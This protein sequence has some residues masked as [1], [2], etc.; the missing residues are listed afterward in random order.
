MK[1]AVIIPSRMNSSRFPGKPLKKILGYTMIEHCYK[2]AC[3]SKNVDDVFVA[4]C[5]SE[6]KE[7]IESIGG[8]VVITSS[9]HKRA[10]T[11]TEEAIEILN[12]KYDLKYDLIIMLQGDEPLIRPDSITK[13][14]NDCKSKDLKILNLIAPIT[15]KEKFIDKNNVKVVFDKNMHALYFSREPIPSSWLEEENIE[16]KFMQIGVIGFSHSSLKKFNKLKESPL[17]KSES[18]DMNRVI[19]NGYKILFSS[20]NYEMIGVDCPNDLKEAEK[21]M[22][23][24]P[25]LD[26]YKNNMLK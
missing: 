1:V 15:T 3:I 10:S 16:N 8:K 4:T 7:H 6:I 26:L 22:K 13:M 9:C 17:E 2:R 11:R 19:E 14:I 24:D 20:I 5:D 18:V 23:R 25:T 21:L 12:N